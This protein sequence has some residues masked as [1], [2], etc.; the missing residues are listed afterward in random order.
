RSVRLSA[1]ATSLP[2][3]SECAVRHEDVFRSRG[4]DASILM[5]AV[6]SWGPVAGGAPV[7]AHGSLL[8]VASWTETGERPTLLSRAG[9][10]GEDVPG[11][12]RRPAGAYPGTASDTRLP[13]SDGSTQG[14]PQPPGHPPGPPSRLLAP[15]AGAYRC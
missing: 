8:I 7:T 6:A 10:R 13:C 15:Q 1:L 11:Q 14:C 12:G 5:V 4:V 2:E 9:A 3:L